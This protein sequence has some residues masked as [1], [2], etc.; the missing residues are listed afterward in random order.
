MALPPELTPPDSPADWQLALP[1]TMRGPATT[2]TRI[3]KGMSGAAVYRVDAGGESFV[4]KLTSADESLGPWQARLEVQRAAAA[5]GLAPEVVHVDEARR[6]VL[7]TLVVDRSWPAYFGNPATRGAAIDALGRMLAQRAHLPTPPGMGRAEV[8]PVLQAMWN[9][10]SSDATL[11]RFVHEVVT[12]LCAEP[13]V[14]QGGPLVM[15]HNDVNPSN[16]VFDGTRVLLLDWDTAAPNDPLYDLATVAM[17]FRMDEGT[18]QQ[19][20][21]AH[22]DAPTV[23]L[24]EAFH[25]YR[26]CAAA[27]SGVAAL[28]AAGARGHVG[29][30]TAVDESPTLG[31][32]YQQL[33]AGT[34]DIQGV[35][36]QWTFGL[37]LVKEAAGLPR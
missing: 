4:L 18:C 30:E 2:L 9:A 6:A 19:L 31:E 5:A 13:P 32:I 15:S 23:E 22:D 29:S 16:L 37:A 1:S 34:I 20:V 17:F 33:R 21:A 26:R 36:G 25:Y 12:A 8:R 24:P 14:A 11:P 7:S 10:L 3:G 27:L 28:T 35:A